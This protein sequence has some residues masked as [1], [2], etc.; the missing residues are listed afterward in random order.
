MMV[1]DN[2]HI[3][4]M[5]EEAVDALH[6]QENGT[7]VDATFG[8]GGHSRAILS[9]LGSKGRLIA[10]DQDPDAKL[11]ADMLSDDRLLFIPRNFRFIQSFLNYFEIGQVDGVLADLGVS[12]HQFDEGTRGFS[13]RFDGPLDM[14]MNYN[15]GKTAKDVLLDSSPEDLLNMFS[16]Y[17]EVRN[18]R[19]LVKRLQAHP[20]IGSIETTGDF[21]AW[22]EPVIRGPR[23]KYL[24]QV[25]QALRI[26][27]NEEL[28]SLTD[29]LDSLPKCIKPGGYM[30]IITFHSLEDRL[31]KRAIKGLGDSKES[32]DPIFGAQPSNWKEDKVHS[33]TPRSAEVAKNSRARSARLRVACKVNQE[34]K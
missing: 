26:A 24:A 34:A 16:S 20:S 32:Y 22:I 8:G 14:R 4:V 15:H 17:G 25:Y 12:S 18:A 11:N 31:V 7:Y 1:M 28:S 19:E 21:N 10:F 29:F 13:T 33:Q 2:Y 5:L 23:E 9:R 30:A 6:I 27:V 3:P